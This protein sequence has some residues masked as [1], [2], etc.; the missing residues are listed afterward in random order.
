M[1]AKTRVSIEW[2]NLKEAFN[3]IK[4]GALDTNNHCGHSIVGTVVEECL[5][6]SRKGN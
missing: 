6:S 5:A 4:S 2:Y 3:E 1:L